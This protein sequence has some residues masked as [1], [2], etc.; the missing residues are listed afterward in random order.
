[1]KE[2]WV[3]FFDGACPLCLKTQSK[4]PALLSSRIKLTVVDLN[5]EIAKS[6]GYDLKQVVLETNK[7]TY[8]GYH[9][10]LQILAE[11]KYDW[12]TNILIRPCFIVFYYFVSRNR[13]ILSKFI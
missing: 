5:S 7:K 6:K 11:T 1:M 4:L 12:A 13:K 3:L 2:R 8:F 9:A 10:W